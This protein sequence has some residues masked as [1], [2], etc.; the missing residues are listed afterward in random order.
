MIYATRIFLNNITDE[1]WQIAGLPCGS[2]NYGCGRFGLGIC[3]LNRLRFFRKKPQ[4]CADQLVIY[5]TLPVYKDNNF[6]G[7]CCPV[8]KK[9]RCCPVFFHIKIAVIQKLLSSLAKKWSCCP[10]KL[11]SLYK[12]GCRKFLIT[13]LIFS[14]FFS[15]NLEIFE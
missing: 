5:Y 11:L 15:L 2:K 8:S 13:F 12:G 9:I 10:K 4:K 7:C 1:K 3:G 14:I 6:S